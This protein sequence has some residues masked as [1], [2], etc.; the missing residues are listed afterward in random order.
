MKDKILNKKINKRQTGTEPGYILIMTLTLS[1]IILSFALTVAKIIEREVIF[2]RMVA[3][4]REAYFAADSGLECAQYVDNVFRDN[5][6]G[7]PLFLNRVTTTPKA[8]FESN[9]LLNVFFATTSIP[10]TI[11]INNYK[12]S[13]ICSAKDNTYN[14]IFSDANTNSFSAGF[15]ANRDLVINNLKNK[16]T[17][18]SIVGNINQATTTFGLVIREKD[19]AGKDIFRCVVVDFNKQSLNNTTVTAKYSIISTGYSSCDL[20]NKN[21]V[22]RTIFRYSSD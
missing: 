13:I 17:S 5:S 9:A 22:S 14:R 2:S 21:T 10:T 11:N 16:I 3:N 19:P 20:N 18:Y 8:D 1:S 7:I 4:N 15:V 6:K 12:I